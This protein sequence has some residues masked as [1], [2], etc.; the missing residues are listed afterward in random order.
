MRWWADLQFLIVALVRLRAAAK[1]FQKASGAKIAEAIEA[2]DAALP[3]LRKMRD[4]AEHID[5]YAID[6]GRRMDVSRC[7]LAVGAWDGTTFSWMNSTLNI[8]KA[9]AAAEALFRAL[10]TER[11]RVLQRSEREAT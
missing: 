3:K 5:E 7:E 4:V 9:Q 1:T 2:F 6:S 8:E 10:Q 11:D